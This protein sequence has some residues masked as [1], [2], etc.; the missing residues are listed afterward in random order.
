MGFG[1]WV[2]I[3]RGSYY[4]GIYVGGPNFRKSPISSLCNVNV[5]LITSPPQSCF[6]PRGLEGSKKGGGVNSWNLGV[7]WGSGGVSRQGLLCFVLK[8]SASLKTEPRSSF[9]PAQLKSLLCNGTLKPFSVTFCIPGQK[10]LAVVA[11][12]LFSPDPPI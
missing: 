12:L 3:I 10:N 4:L 11:P 8:G 7:F 1:V 2:L 5:A 6:G 9:K